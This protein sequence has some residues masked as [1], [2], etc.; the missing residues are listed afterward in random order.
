MKN[1]KK[2]YS[3]GFSHHFLLPVLAVI[4][5]GAIGVYTMSLS[6]AATSGCKESVLATGSKGTCVKNAERMLNA[7]HGTGSDVKVDTKY[8]SL[9]A[10]KTARFQ[11][12]QKL[13]VDGKIGKQTW[14]K[15]CKLSYSGSAATA[16]RKACSAKRTATPPI[17]T[18]QT[19][20]TASTTATTT[21]TAATNED[22][23]TTASVN[24]SSTTNQPTTTPS[25]TSVTFSKLK[26]F[27]DTAGSSGAIKAG[28]L[29][30]SARLYEAS[31][32]DITS[33]SNLIS[34]GLIID[35]RQTSAQK[36]YPD[37]AVPGVSR[38][39]YPMTSTTDY[40][41]FVTGSSDRTAIKNAIT[42]IAT[43]PGKVLIHCTL[44]RDRTGWITAMV[45]YTLGANDSQVMNE[46][47][48][49]SS[50]S[51]STLNKGL[52]KAR[53]QYGSIDNYIKTGLGVSDATLASLRA[54][55][56]P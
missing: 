46:Y 30:R 1:Y 28:V 9:T 10:K 29:Y 13:A 54:K 41:K 26:N 22:T 15:L 4:V 25:G 39:S 27:R 40:T 44:G 32:S 37:K 31:A 18:T 45:M 7:T 24:A 51:K 8:T 49:T 17:K 6:S 21:A 3:R 34:G 50:T 11:K 5:V 35:L 55:L 38:V 47:L 52:D 20:T 42:D 14:G 2:L 48:K 12:K 36:S 19:T 33:L 16:K 53:S 56:K 23:S 43:S